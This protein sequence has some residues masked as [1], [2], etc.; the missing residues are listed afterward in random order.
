[1]LAYGFRRLAGLFSCES[2]VETG[3]TAEA[4]S[5]VLF[6][7]EDVGRP[8]AIDQGEL[9]R[10]KASLTRGYVRSFETA[11]QLVRAAA[12]LITYG[13]DEAT[14]DRF[15]PSVESVMPNDVQAA[16]QRFIRPAEATA[17]IVGDGS[18][19]ADALGA[20]GRPVSTVAPEF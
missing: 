9:D 7:L 13:L 5:D 12:L 16:A 4:I 17:V 6:E 2:S 15:V 18:R 1:V 20:L 14:F 3:R 11:S 19:L 8:G 10:A